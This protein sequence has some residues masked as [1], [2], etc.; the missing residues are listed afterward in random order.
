MPVQYSTIVDEH[1]AVRERVGLFD[2]SHMG[3]LTFD[4]PGMLDWLER[5]TTN[6]VARLKLDQIQYSLMANETG[7]PDRRHPGLPP[8]VRLLRGVQR[9]EPARRAGPAREPPGGRRGQLP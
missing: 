6:H 2:I 7:R 1:R 3:R 5:V 4:G 8:P 9:L